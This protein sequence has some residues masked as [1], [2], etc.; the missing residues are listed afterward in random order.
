MCVCVCI[1]N[2]IVQG[3]KLGSCIIF[4]DYPHNEYMGMWITIFSL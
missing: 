1:H 4:S 2:V 3:N